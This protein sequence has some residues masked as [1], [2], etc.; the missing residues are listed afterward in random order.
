VVF[1]VELNLTSWLDNPHL[2]PLTKNLVNLDRGPLP[3]DVVLAQD[4]A[5]DLVGATV[6]VYW[7]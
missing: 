4:K 5:W 2:W 3:E 6:S 1:R 7:H